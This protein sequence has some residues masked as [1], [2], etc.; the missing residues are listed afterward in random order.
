MSRPLPRAFF[1]LDQQLVRSGI[2]L[3]LSP[4]ARLAYI[5]LCASC[6]RQ[7]VSIWSRAKLMQLSACQDPEEWQ[8]LLVELESHQLVERMVDHSPPALRLVPLQSE[9]MSAGMPTS[10]AAADA[11]TAATPSESA[12][13]APMAGPSP[14]VVHTH[15][16]IHFGAGKTESHAE[17]GNAN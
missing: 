1:W 5:A 17:S 8:R 7:G 15:T 10:R 14:I 13:L 4:Q 9:G 6:D 3:K 2:W 12:K 16:T 11:L